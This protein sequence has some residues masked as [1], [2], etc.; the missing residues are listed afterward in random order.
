MSITYGGRITELARTRGSAPAVTD[1]DSHG[2]ERSLSWR[3]L[4]DLSGRLATSLHSGGLAPGDLMAVCLPNCV[5]HFVADVAAWKVGAVPVALRWDLPDWEL[6]RV[7]DVL[8]PRV[9][10]GGEPGDIV[11]RASTTPMADAG[12]APPHRFGVCSSGSTGT[13]KVI[14]HT[15]PGLYAA[16]QRSTS[17]V[18][19]SYRILSTPQQLLVPNALYHSASMTTAVLNMVSGNH[20]IVLKRFDPE[21][22][23]AAVV[24]HRVTGFMAPTPMLLRLVRDPAITR[25][26]FDSIE[27]VQHGASP[28]PKWLARIWIELLGPERFFTSYGAAEAVGVVA[29]RGD[30]WL[31][32]PGTLGRGA[33]GTDI[34]ILGEQGQVLAPGE[35]GQIF[36][37]RPGGPS[38]TYG[39]HGVAPLDIR[40]DGFATVGDLG[41]LDEDG[42]L[43]LSD[44]RVDLIV[45]GGA[46]VYPSEVEAAVGEHGGIDDVVVI[47]LPD[48][49]WGKRV[50]AIVQLAPDAELSEED[51]RAYARSRL[52]PYKVPKTVEFVTL[53]PRSA[54]TKVNRAALIAERT[55]APP[56]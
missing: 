44:R 27:W 41:W 53:M 3:D 11:A 2:R 43:Y 35:V 15:S 14:L 16:T 47:G 6:A 33:L 18:V 20:T 40:S 45:S 29:C 9:I 19:E 4:D 32:H 30:E 50:H 17:A 1:V 55:A 56:A 8:E 49:E 34:L 39:G 37:R 51:I 5:E 48:D 38:G 10:F 46:N 25:E 7:L 36:L 54:A 26:Q 42:F 52:A 13:P 12:V 24:R 22:V 23:L 31:A 28:L 21:L